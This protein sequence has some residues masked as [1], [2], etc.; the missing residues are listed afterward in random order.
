MT[1]D[2]HCK[3]VSWLPFAEWWYNTIYHTTLGMTPYQALYRVPPTYYE[4]N[5]IDTFDE[6]AVE[7]LKDHCI[8]IEVLKDRLQKAHE[9]MRHYADKGRTNRTFQVGE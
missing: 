9:R 6:V 7:L 5:R 8:A 2:H 1:G 4:F 3:W